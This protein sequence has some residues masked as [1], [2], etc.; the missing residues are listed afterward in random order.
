MLYV[1]KLFSIERRRVTAFVCLQSNMALTGEPSKTHKHKFPWTFQPL[2]ELILSGAFLVIKVMPNLSGN[3]SDF[4]NHKG[5]PSETEFYTNNAQTIGRTQ[6]KFW[7]GGRITSP[8]A[9]RSFFQEH[10]FPYQISDQAYYARC[11]KC[12]AIFHFGEPMPDTGH[13]IDLLPK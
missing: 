12:P 1:R 8:A 3:D 2:D 5:I 10:A 6:K 13:S 9:F 7:S 11:I 4:H